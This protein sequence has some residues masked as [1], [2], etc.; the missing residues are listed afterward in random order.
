MAYEQ[1]GNT[2]YVLFE[3]DPLV[4]RY[5]NLQRQADSKNR[6]LLVKENATMK[7]E[8]FHS[9]SITDKSMGYNYIYLDYV[10]KAVDGIPVRD[11]DGKL[12]KTWNIV[13]YG[14]VEKDD[15]WHVDMETWGN[16][17]GTGAKDFQ[18]Y[19]TIFFGDTLFNEAQLKFQNIAKNKDM[20]DILDINEVDN[21]YYGLFKDESSATKDKNLGYDIYTVF[22]TAVDGGVVK[23]LPYEIV[24]PQMYRSS[25]DLY[26]L[27]AV[28]QIP[29]GV[30]SDGNTQYKLQL[31]EISVPDNDLYV[32][33]VVDIQDLLEN[34]EQVDMSGGFSV[35][36]VIM[37]SFRMKNVD[38]YFFTLSNKGF[39]K[40]FYRNKI[41]QLSID[42][43]DGY[44]GFK[45]RLKEA[46]EKTILQ[47][48]L[49]EKHHKEQAY[50]FDN[51]ARK[52]NQFAP[53]FS[54]FSL[55]PTEFT[56]TQ[57][58]GVI[59]DQKVDDTD[60]L[61]DHRP[62]SVQVSTDILYTDGM[63]MD[64]GD[65]PG[66]ITAAISN[67]ST[68]YED[69]H[70][71]IKVQRN[72]LIEQTEFYDY[73]YESSGKVLLDLYLI[74]YIYRINSNNTYDLYI[75]IPTTRTKYLNRIAGTLKPDGTSRVLVDDTRTRRNF[76]DEVLPN[77]LDE[78]TTKLRVY[79]DRKYISVGNIELVEISG[80][81]IPLQ[82]YRDVPNNGLYDSIALES[83]WDGAL[84][85]LIDPDKDINKVMLEFEVY[86]TDSQSIHIQGK[87]LIN[88]AL[89]DKK[90]KFA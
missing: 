74:P 81:S 43:L 72:P 11:A 30:D 63:F 78:S 57:D 51:I 83:R 44:M 54:T 52:I 70:T 62:D 4:Y 89:D 18:Q 19:N 33:R 34:T 61:S 65:N 88:R 32:D 29:V 90:Y 36:D 16:D 68:S 46:L 9:I 20:F 75:N 82:I 42:K 6:I 2:L 53:D 15:G 58:I 76:Y 45:P 73:I 85:E 12:L 84:T 24:T 39:H 87:T 69:D 1:T 10:D 14:K 47:K 35:S 37:S 5:D 31:R 67:P 59:P 64:G 26:S 7:I 66:F 23:R 25:D 17:P 60:S 79:I 48:H 41:D 21:C 77:N 13:L 28:T 56:E 71:I 8:T 86:G 55:I 50:Y 27:F 3:N 80:N 40:F 22:K 49:D 38:S